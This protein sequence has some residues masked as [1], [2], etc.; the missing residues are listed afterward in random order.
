[1]PHNFSSLGIRRGP[2]PSFPFHL[3]FF[4]TATTETQ[5]SKDR[6]HKKGSPPGQKPCITLSLESAEHPTDITVSLNTENIPHVLLNLLWHLQVLWHS[7]W[8]SSLSGSRCFLVPVVPILDMFSLSSLSSSVV[9]K[10]FCL[11]KFC[12]ALHTSGFWCLGS[13]RL[14]RF[15]ETPWP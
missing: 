6:H 9:L 11:R 10:G 15:L 7:V 13:R 8:A 5:P 14:H 2:A 1:M 12:F 3:D 4:I